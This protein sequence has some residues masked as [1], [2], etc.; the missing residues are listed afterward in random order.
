MGPEAPAKACSNCGIFAFILPRAHCASTAGSVSPATSRSSIAR[1]D[2]PMMSV[3][4]PATLMLA[5]SKRLLQP[6]HLR[7]AFLHH[8]G[9]V[10][11]QLPQLPL[12]PVR[13][14]AGA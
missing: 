13:D 7:A 1:P 2:L 4:I 6:V 9:A 3:A 8:A 12:G 10:A 5:P 11:R 14:E